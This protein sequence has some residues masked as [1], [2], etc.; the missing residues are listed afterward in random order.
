MIRFGVFKDVEVAGGRFNSQGR[1]AARK[2]GG[3]EQRAPYPFQNVS[4]LTFG[5]PVNECTVLYGCEL[6]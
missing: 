4:N 6:V 3:V 1:T 5:C 2:V